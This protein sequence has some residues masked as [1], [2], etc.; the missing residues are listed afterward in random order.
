VSE[1]PSRFRSGHLT[2]ELLD[3]IL[4]LVTQLPHDLKGVAR[5]CGIYPAD[6]LAWFAVGQDPQCIDPLMA[7][8]SRAV[9][10]ARF[11]LAAANYARVVAA[12]NGSTKRKT[13]TKPGGDVEETVEDVL[14]QAWAVEKLDAL[15]AASPWEI[16]PNADQADELHKMMR[17][18]EPTPLL[19]EG[20]TVLEP[21][22][23]AEASEPTPDEA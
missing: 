2:R 21:A 7:E 20:A 1:T 19:T 15:Q 17:E 13:V 5:A 16:S 9:S 10:R 18:L 22:A 14:P 4:E 8:L 6:L 11:A 23:P 3:E 12:A